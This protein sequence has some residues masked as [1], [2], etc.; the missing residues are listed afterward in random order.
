[1][2]LRRRDVYGIANILAVHEQLNG[3]HGLKV[4]VNKGPPEAVRSH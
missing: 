4:E 1:V 2:R 3:V